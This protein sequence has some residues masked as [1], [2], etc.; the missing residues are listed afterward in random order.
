MSFPL[1]VFFVSASHSSCVP[2]LA[3]CFSS[4]FVCISI[5]HSGLKS[6]MDREVSYYSVSCK[7]IQNID[8]TLEWIIKRTKSGSK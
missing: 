5:I 6:I 7:N 8:K 3:L 2:H 4:C 1:L